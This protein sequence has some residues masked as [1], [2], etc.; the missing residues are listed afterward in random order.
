MWA[1]FE[2]RGSVAFTYEELAKRAGVARQTVYS[3]FP[4]RAALFIALADHTRA[5]FDVPRLSAAV[6]DAPTAHGT[7]WPP[8]SI[9]TW[10]T[11]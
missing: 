3:H 4:D 11:R 8:R 7:R 5:M 6:F 9:S 2:E 1:L 10:G